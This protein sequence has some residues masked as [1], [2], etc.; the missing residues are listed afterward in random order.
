MRAWPPLAPLLSLLVLVVLVLLSHTPTCQ[1]NLYPD[2]PG[3]GVPADW[4]PECWIAG[5]LCGLSHT[6]SASVSS[7]LTPH[8]PYVYQCV[9]AA[10]A[11]IQVGGDRMFYWTPYTSQRWGNVLSPYWQ[12]RALAL[13]AGHV[14]VMHQHTLPTEV[15]VSPSPFAR[16]KTTRHMACAF[17]FC[18]DC[19]ALTRTLALRR[20]G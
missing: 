11:R 19:R 20:G 16:N 6:G 17:V 2:C 1:A 3:V 5:G 12:A 18:V 14:S 9:V 4:M 10:H 15:H 8:F 13:L 7:I